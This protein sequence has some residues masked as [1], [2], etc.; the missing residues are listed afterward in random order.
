[1]NSIC[2]YL[3]LVRCSH[4]KIT[5]YTVHKDAQSRL[6]WEVTFTVGS[7]KCTFNSIYVK[8]VIEF[9]LITMWVF[10]MFEERIINLTVNVPI[11]NPVSIHEEE[12]QTC[13]TFVIII[14]KAVPNIIF[15][16]IRSKSILL[17]CTC[18]P[19][20]VDNDELP[21]PCIICYPIFNKNS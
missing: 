2:V 17:L 11:Q 4:C 6:R 16:C 19:P 7:G 20:F 9:T 13:W 18:G 5:E 1:M 14:I 12:C 15:S 10:W 8:H 21:V 3:T